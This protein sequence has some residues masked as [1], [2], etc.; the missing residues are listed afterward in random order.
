MVLSYLMVQ[1]SIV[2]SGPRKDSNSN[3]MKIRAQKFSTL[4]C[5]DRIDDILVRD[6][7][8]SQNQNRI[9]CPRI[10]HLVREYIVK[11]QQN[12]YKP[13]ITGRLLKLYRK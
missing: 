6:F 11:R 9:N 2:Q 5:E 3:S 4:I 12:M 1:C 13:E 8:R 10:I 7:S